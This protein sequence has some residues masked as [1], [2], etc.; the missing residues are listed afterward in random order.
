MS[1]MLRISRTQAGF[2]IVELVTSITIIPIVLTLFIVALSVNITAVTKSKL[3]FE[4]DSDLRGAIDIIERD[5]RFSEAFA[6][7]VQAPFADAYGAN[8]SG[9][10]GG[11]AWSHA[12]VP[13]EADKRVLILRVPST[14]QSSLSNARMPVFTDD[15]YDCGTSMTYNPELMHTVLYF[16]RNDNLYRRI[17]TD[18]TTPVC[19]GPQIQ[20]QSCPADV[21]PWHDSCQARDERI[22]TRVSAFRVAY[23]E[24][25]AA[26][27]ISDAYTSGD[28]EVLDIADDV[29][30]TLETSQLY[31][32]ETLTA[33]LA[34]RIGKANAQ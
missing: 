19:N 32:G 27:P 5:V 28:P 23:H 30:V 4:L 9:S 29:V 33:S 34:L 24:A 11:Q 31:A 20:K 21:S 14:T 8:N 26:S 2:T 6:K 1:V 12:G 10:S 25:L 22:L 17:L 7:N 13:A 16:V 15:T 3:Q 18:T